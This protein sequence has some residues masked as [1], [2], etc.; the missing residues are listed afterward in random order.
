MIIKIQLKFINTFIN[1][2]VNHKNYN[3]FFSLIFFV[4]FGNFNHH[5]MFHKSQVIAVSAIQQK[6]GK[7]RN[8]I[9]NQKPQK[10]AKINLIWLSC[11]PV[12]VGLLVTVY[13]DQMGQKKFH[14]L[15]TNW[16]MAIC[17][18][19]IENHPKSQKQKFYAAKRKPD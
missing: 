10:L 13:R 2:C 1:V 17:Q 16:A 6:K 11:Q 8:A 3:Q 19:A 9:R 18:L 7:Q 4:L 5:K 15:T 12:L 14:I